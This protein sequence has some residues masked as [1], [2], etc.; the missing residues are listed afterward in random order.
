[1]K[2]ESI[3]NTPSETTMPLYLPTYLP[4]SKSCLKPVDTQLHGMLIITLVMSKYFTLYLAFGGFIG[5]ES[6]VSIVR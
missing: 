3:Q 5:E 6:R 2:N 4:L 1:M